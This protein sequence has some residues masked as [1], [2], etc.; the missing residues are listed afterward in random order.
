ME[1]KLQSGAFLLCLLSSYSGDQIKEAEADGAYETFVEEKNYIQF[2]QGNLQEG[3]Y[4]GKMGVDGR[5]ELNSI[6]KEQD[7]NAWSGLL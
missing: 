3:E 2:L 4:L 7:G 6:L 1:E 5:T